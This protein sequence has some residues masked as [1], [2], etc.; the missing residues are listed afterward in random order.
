MLRAREDVP[1][2]VAEIVALGVGAILGELLGEA[3]IGRAME[4][5]DEA[6]DDGLGDEVE[7]R[8]EAR[9]AGSRKRWSISLCSLPQRRRDAE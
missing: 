6:I 7:A 5:R 3:E 2:D 1:I 8:M 4:A 9:V